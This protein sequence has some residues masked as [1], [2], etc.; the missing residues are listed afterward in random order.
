MEN[1]SNEMLMQQIKIANSNLIQIYNSL[2]QENLQM[3][4]LIVDLQFRVQDLMNLT[5]VVGFLGRFP[6]FNIETKNPI[7]YESDDHIH[8]R[9]TRNDNTR[10]PKFKQKCFELFGKEAS[11]LDLGCAGG[12]LVADFLFS[13]LTAA[14]IE[15]SDFS[16]QIARAEW[17]RISNFLFT[18]DITKPFSL[19]ANGNQHSHKFTVVS[20]WEVL[21]HIPE[22][23]L[24]GLLTNIRNHLH[25]QGFFVASIAQFED[26]DPRTGAKWH[27]TIKSQEWW[28]SKFAEC[29]FEIVPNI[30]HP[31]D[32]PRGTGNG[33]EDWNVLA[34]PEHGFHVAARKIN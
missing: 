19:N 1:N 7:A 2:K 11:L 32:F 12:G 20:A 34:N 8:P 21:E 27:V 23:L 26:F 15:G 30:F 24:T 16:R 31:S 18:A 13:G 25:D 5:D 3:K 28:K 29:G 14:G 9:G 10:Y 17:S 22:D 33:D 6:T 4:K